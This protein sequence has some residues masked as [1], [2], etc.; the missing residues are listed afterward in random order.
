MEVMEEKSSGAASASLPEPPL[1]EESQADQPFA[2]EKAMEEA[3]ASA[4]KKKK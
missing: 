2:Q 4:D 3:A 1:E